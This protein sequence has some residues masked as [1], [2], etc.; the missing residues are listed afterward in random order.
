M[1]LILMCLSNLSLLTPGISPFIPNDFIFL[2]L[3]GRV[4]ILVPSVILLI[5]CAMTLC[6]PCSERFP[7]PCLFPFHEVSQALSQPQWRRA[8]NENMQAIREKKHMG[9]CRSFTKKG[10][11][12]VHMGVLCEVTTQW[13]CREVHTNIRGWFSWHLYPF[14]KDE[15][16]LYIDL[17][18]S[19]SG[20]A[21][22]SSWCQECIPT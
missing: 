1:S 12:K 15:F 8:M 5:M 6:L 19:S 16:H 2:L 20:V 13:Y 3:L 4:N 21:F 11:C 22:D 7:P 14:S 18:Y 9:C 10:A 17:Y